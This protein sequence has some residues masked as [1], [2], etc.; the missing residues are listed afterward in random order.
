M[1]VTHLHARR[2]AGL[3]TTLAVLAAS[4]GSPGASAPEVQRETPAVLPRPDFHFEGKIGKTYKQSDPP[5]FPQ[6][7]KAPEGAPNVVLILLDAP[8]TRAGRT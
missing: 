6:P 5:E 1:E 4:C 7:V 3:F 8:R 2:L